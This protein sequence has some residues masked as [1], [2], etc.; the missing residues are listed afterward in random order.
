MSRDR[1]PSGRP[2]Y[3]DRKGE[4]ISLEQWGMMRHGE[5]PT[6]ND[7]Y[8]RVGLDIYPSIEDSANPLDYEAIVTISTVWVGMNLSIGFPGPPLIF[9]TMCFGGDY[10]QSCMRYATE[11][12]AEEGHRRTVEDIRAG[13][14]PWFLHE[15]MHPATNGDAEED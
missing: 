6:A 5:D 15:D 3:F 11:A 13:R 14:A 4:P 9:E 7:E 1:Y 8:T 12:E 2:V 10:D